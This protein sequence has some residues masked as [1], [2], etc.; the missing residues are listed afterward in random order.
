MR[1][2]VLS[3][4]LVAGCP[5][6]LPAVPTAATATKDLQ[7]CWNDKTIDDADRPFM[8]ALKKALVHAGYD[9]E[10]SV[11]DATLGY[12]VQ[13]ASEHGREFY[14]SATLTVSDSSG[15]VDKIHLE[16][17]EPTDVPL[18]EPDRL[19]TLLVNELNKSEKVAALARKW[20]AQDP[21]RLKSSDCDD[22]LSDG[23]CAIQKNK[24]VIQ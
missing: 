8:S 24:N 19:G 5:K 15:I 6:P 1:A 12:H 3:L 13:S 18:D 2:A 21:L 23:G 7:I 17:S 11:C 22:P 9:L 20:H 10:A 16:F 4:L 14:K